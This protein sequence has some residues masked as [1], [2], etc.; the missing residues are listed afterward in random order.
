[1]L[2]KLIHKKL[3]EVSRHLGSIPCRKAVR[4]GDISV[5]QRLML[6]SP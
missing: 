5:T 6:E 3:K 4:P 2:Q 1:M